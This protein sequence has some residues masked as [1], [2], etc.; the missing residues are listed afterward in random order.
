[1]ITMLPVRG[2]FA[3]GDTIEV[4]WPGGD[5]ILLEVAATDI[6]AKYQPAAIEEARR[7][8]IP[9]R[10]PVIVEEPDDKRLALN[11]GHI[12]TV[13]EDEPYWPQDMGDRLHL[14]PPGVLLVEPGSLDHKKLIR[15][16]PPDKRTYHSLAQ[17]VRESIL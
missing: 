15:L 7:Q 6:A 8:G 9:L 4:I 16:P 3:V 12:L 11:P 13:P 14:A 1:M 10:R 2:T 5:A 17:L